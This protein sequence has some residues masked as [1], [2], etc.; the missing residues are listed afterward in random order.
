MLA[1]S[2]MNKRGQIWART[3]AAKDSH[4]AAPETWTGGVTIWGHLSS[5]SQRMLMH[6]DRYA[7]PLTAAWTFHAGAP[8]TAGDRL[9]IESRTYDVLGIDDTAPD[10]WHAALSEVV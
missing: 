5:P 1:A 3:T 4:G 2:F 6:A 10:V 7:A 9:L 8:V